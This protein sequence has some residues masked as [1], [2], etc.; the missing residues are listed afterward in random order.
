MLLCLYRQR[1]RKNSKEKRIIVGK[2]DINK[3]FKKTLFFENSPIILWKNSEFLLV[4]FFL[5][6]NI[7]HLTKMSEQKISEE[8]K[9]NILNRW[10]LETK[11]SWDKSEIELVSEAIVFAAEKHTTQRRKDKAK[12]PYI[13]H[14]LR[15]MRRLIR[16]NIHDPVTLAVAVLHDTVEDTNTT[17]EEIE[18][19]FGKEVAI[20]VRDVT[21]DKSLSK[22]ERKR[23]QIIHTESGE[24]SLPGRFVKL[25]DKLDNLA[26]RVTNPPEFCSKEENKGYVIWA[27]HVVLPI[28]SLNDLL[29]R[30]LCDLF[31]K[32]DIGFHGIVLI[33][34]RSNGIISIPDYSNGLRDMSSD[35]ERYY[36]LVQKQEDEKC[37]K[38]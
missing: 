4:L 20:G 5:K 26:D 3:N 18:K 14:P 23:Q 35:L 7:Q 21:D 28:M 19:L 22:V 37:A 8:Q 2:T 34:G 9:Q 15:V 29:A 31:G 12:S 25:A 38:K 30:Q 10:K 17:F 6:T 32:A 16:A 11:K 33:P 13:E 36:A 24:M 1:T 27:L